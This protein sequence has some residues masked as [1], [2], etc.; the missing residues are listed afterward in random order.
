MPSTGSPPALPAALASAFDEFEAIRELARLHENDS[1]D[2]FA[3]FLSV[4]T[5]AANGRDAV[6]LAPSLPRG[7]RVWPEPP[8]PS[9]ETGAVADAIADRASVLA[10]RLD[11]A[12]LAAET[13]G[14]SQACQ[15]AAAIARQIAGLMASR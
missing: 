14:D 3:A 13:A 5:S 1:P 8:S 7:G 11:Q 9:A 10:A 4:A 2:L 15:D 12:A 6:G